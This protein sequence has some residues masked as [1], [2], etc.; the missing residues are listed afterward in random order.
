MSQ[1]ILKNRLEKEYLPRLSEKRQNEMIA[2]KPEELAKVLAS[3]TLNK[4]IG[5]IRK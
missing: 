1:L 5:N 2:R 4:V 3:K